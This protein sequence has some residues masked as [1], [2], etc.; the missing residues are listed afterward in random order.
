MDLDSYDAG[1]TSQGDECKPPARNTGIS[2]AACTGAADDRLRQLRF[3]GHSDRNQLRRPLRSTSLAAGVCLPRLMLTH[4]TATAQRAAGTTETDREARAAYS[5]TPRPGTTETEREAAHPPANS[6]L[7]H[8]LDAYN[9]GV[10]ATVVS[11]SAAPAPQRTLLIRA[12]SRRY[13][14]SHRLWSR[15]SGV[16]AR[17]GYGW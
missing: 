9:C 12:V 6:R 15:V 4:P 7:S 1:T 10:I 3:R 2:W 13:V 17:F 14:L 5:L 8:Y 11:C 16:K